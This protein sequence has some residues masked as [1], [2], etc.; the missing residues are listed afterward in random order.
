MPETPYRHLTT[1]TDR[2]VLVLT[3]TPAEMRGEEL[4]AAVLEELCAAAAAVPGPPRVALDLG[5]V[6]FLTSLG[7]SALLG[8]RRRLMPAGGRLLLCALSPAVA[9]VLFTTRLAS[10]EPSSVSPL[11]VVADVEAA[12]AQ[13]AQAAG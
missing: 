2:G 9:E 6:T 4:C 7:I 12:V 5:R 3:L 11:A 8:F 1:R 13:L 10:A